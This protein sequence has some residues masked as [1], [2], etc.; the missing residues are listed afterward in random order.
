[1][2]LESVEELWSIRNVLI[3]VQLLEDLIMHWTQQI[4]MLVKLMEVREKLMVKLEILI[5]ITGKTWNKNQNE[6]L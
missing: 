1:M 4:D 6:E 3:V 2:Q 5:G